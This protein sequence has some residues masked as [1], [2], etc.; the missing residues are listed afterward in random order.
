MVVL[1]GFSLTLQASPAALVCMIPSGVDG[2][3]NL[4]GHGAARR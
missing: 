4:G 1:L 3:D 2:V